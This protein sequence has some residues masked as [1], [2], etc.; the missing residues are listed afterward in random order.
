[1]IPLTWIS[2]STETDTRI[3]LPGVEDRGIGKNCYQGAAFWDDE[4][5]LNLAVMVIQPC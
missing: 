3:C 4:N 1:M 5:V 2:E